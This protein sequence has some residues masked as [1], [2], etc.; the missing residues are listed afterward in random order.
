MPLM[1]R[2]AHVSLRLGLAN[3][4][5]TL[6]ELDAPVVLMSCSDID[7]LQSSSIDLASTVLELEDRSKHSALEVSKVV[8]SVIS[9]FTL[10]VIY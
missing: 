2:H 8:V 9:L 7:K 3:V 5:I 6:V 10:C 1:F 4:Q